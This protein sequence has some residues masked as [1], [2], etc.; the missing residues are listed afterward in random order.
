MRKGNIESESLANT[1]NSN[2]NFQ[3][4]SPTGR[5]VGAWVGGQ[6]QQK[7]IIRSGSFSSSIGQIKIIFKF[8]LFVSKNLYDC[9]E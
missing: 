2:D 7:K 8:Y 3:S 1:I 5:A 4:P 9:Y 6:K